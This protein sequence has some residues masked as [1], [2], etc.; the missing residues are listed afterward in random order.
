MTILIM[1]GLTALGIFIVLWK[2]GIKKFTGYM[3]TTEVALFTLLA[4]LFIGTMSGMMIGMVAGIA[5][6]V[7]LY[8]SKKL[9]GSQRLQRRGRFVSWQEVRKR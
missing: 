5:L 4:F 3:V 1:G 9:F 8:I 7:G 6:S 2:C